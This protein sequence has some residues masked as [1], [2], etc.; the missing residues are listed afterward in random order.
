MATKTEIKARLDE[1]GITYGARDSKAALQELLVEAE[2]AKAEVEEAA[3][4]VEAEAP[5]LQEVGEI[6]N[7]GLYDD[8]VKRFACISRVGGKVDEMNAEGYREI[9]QTLQTYLKSE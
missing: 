9:I 3:E 8:G 2:G 7:I 6:A 1:L 5:P 4:V